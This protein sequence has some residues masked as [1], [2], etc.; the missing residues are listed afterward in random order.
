T[1]AFGDSLDTK[2][3]KDIIEDV[4]DQLFDSEDDHTRSNEW[5]LALDNSDEKFVVD[6]QS[7][8]TSCGVLAIFAIERFI[9]P[10]IE[11]DDSGETQNLR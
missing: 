8:E 7:D 2:T 9:N 3:P 11:S 10:D 4:I 6:K 1:I 5:R